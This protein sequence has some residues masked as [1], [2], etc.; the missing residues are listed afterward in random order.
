MVYAQ[1]RVCPWEWDAQ[2][3]RGFWNTN[4]SPNLG[5]TIRSCNNQQQKRSCWIVDFAV[6][7]DLRVK[8]KE[9]EKR[10]KNL[11]LAGELKKPWKKHE[12]N[13]D[14]N[15]NW[16]SCSSHQTIGTGDRAFVNQRTSGGHPNYSIIEIGQ[17]PRN[18]SRLVVSQ[19]PVRHHQVT[20]IWKTRKGVIIRMIDE[21]SKLAQKE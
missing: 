4:T 6:P 20:L 13:D 17:S 9:S 18:L 21:Y 1:P 14:T 3:P 5:Q 16:C 19:T 10:E 15:Y 12:S 11:D 7:A 2:I 8:L